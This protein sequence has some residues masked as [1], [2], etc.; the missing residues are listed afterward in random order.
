MWLRTAAAELNQLQARLALLA[1]AG[2][3]QP[4]CSLVG[5]ELPAPTCQRLHPCR[6]ERRSHAPESIQ[7]GQPVLLAR[8]ATSTST[9]ER[10]MPRH[11]WLDA[12]Q[13]CSAKLVKFLQSLGGLMRP[14]RGWRTASAEQN[15]L[16]AGLAL[17]AQACHL[18]LGIVKLSSQAGEMF[19]A[20]I[21]GQH[22]IAT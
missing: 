6:T 1:S 17:L 19:S 15:Q 12:V 13:R 3:Q 9:A 14:S 4:V 7:A 18:G 8:P 22:A 20:C 11:S 21:A 5:S 2:T 16:H 10:D